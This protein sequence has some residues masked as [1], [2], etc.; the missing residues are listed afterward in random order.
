MI[1]LDFNFP[2]FLSRAADIFKSG[3]IQNYRRNRRRQRY[4]S[5]WERALRLRDGWW[6]LPGLAEER[7]GRRYRE[8]WQEY[9]RRERAILGRG[10]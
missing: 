8:N 7:D 1:S 3:T 9:L 10:E 5:A 4:F 2:R 6:D